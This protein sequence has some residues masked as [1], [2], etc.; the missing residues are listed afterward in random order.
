MFLGTACLH[1]KSHNINNNPTF[2]FIRGCDGAKHSAALYRGFSSSSLG[3]LYELSMASLCVL[4][5]KLGGGMP[6]STMFKNA[7]LLVSAAFE[8]Y[9][10][11]IYG[12][13]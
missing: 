13:G 8:L 11:K 7:A 6:C 1:L 5:L 9:F 3:C 12:G 4:G 10:I 2:S